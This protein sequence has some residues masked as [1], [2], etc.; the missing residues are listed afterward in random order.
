MSLMTGRLLI[1]DK[2]DKCG[3][4]FPKSCKITFPDKIPVT[5]GFSNDPKNVLG[6][7]TVRKDDSS[8]ACD[9]ELHDYISNELYIGGYYNNVKRHTEDGMTIIDAANLCGIAVITEAE[10]ADPELKITAKKGEVK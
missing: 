10:S 8:L 6:T 4:I 1:F 3:R 9:A 7:G 5:F 2:P